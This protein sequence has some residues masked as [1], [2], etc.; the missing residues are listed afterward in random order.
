MRCPS[1]HGRGTIEHKVCEGT[2]IRGFKEGVGNNGAGR[3]RCPA[4]GGTG[5]V[6]RP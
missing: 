2:G 4:C 6:F 5:E 1:R 3:A